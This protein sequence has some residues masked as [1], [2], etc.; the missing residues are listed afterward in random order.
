[1]VVPPNGW[2]TEENPIEIEIDDLGVPSFQEDSSQE[3][4]DATCF[5]ELT[6]FLYHPKKMKELELLMLVRQDVPT[7]VVL[8]WGEQQTTNVT[9]Y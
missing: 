8:S 2:F 6:N 7:N 9:K 1:M 4:T 5:G 3:K